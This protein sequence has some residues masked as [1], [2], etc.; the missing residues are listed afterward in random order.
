MVKTSRYR[1]WPGSRN[2]GWLL[3]LWAVASVAVAQPVINE[4]HYDPEI[5]TDWVEF[6]E[7]Y[8][9][10][11]QDID[12]AGWSFADAITFTFPPGAIL[13]AL[14]RAYRAPVRDPGGGKPFDAS[15]STSTQSSISPGAGG[16]NSR[17]PSLGNVPMVSAE[18]SRGR[19]GRRPRRLQ[20]L[21]QS[22]LQP[23]ATRSPEKRQ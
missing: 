17:C 4:I 7:L 10:T 9:P 8:N 3:L 11:D 12:L 15:S 16:T 21:R 23:L 18:P 5:K 19:R 13:P 6:V 1:T 20:L 2:A 14:T 22:I